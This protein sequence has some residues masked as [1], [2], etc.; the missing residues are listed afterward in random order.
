[1]FPTDLPVLVNPVQTDNLN[2]ATVFHDVQH[3]DV[4][5]LVEAITSTLGITNSL[6][7]TTIDYLVRHGV[8]LKETRFEG[9]VSP[10]SLSANQ[11]NYNPDPSS[12]YTVIRQNCSANVDITG[13][14]GGALG[15]VIIWINIGATNTQTFKNESGSS[16]AANRFSLGADVVLAAGQMAF[17]FYDS[18]ASR[19]KILSTGAS[20]GGGGAPTTAAYAI[21]AASPDG[22][23]VN[24]VAIGATPTGDLAGTSSV[25]GNVVIKGTHTDAAVKTHHLEAHDFFDTAI[26]SALVFATP[27]SVGATNV[28]GTADTISRGD[29]QHAGTAAFPGL[30]NIVATVSIA[31]SAADFL[32]VGF[33]IPTADMVAGIM[34][35]FNAQWIMTNTSGT[36]RSIDLKIKYGGTTIHTGNS[37]LNTGV[38]NKEAILNTFVTFRTI[39][40]SGTVIVGTQTSKDASNAEHT[41][42]TGTTTVNTTTN[43]A[44]ELYAAFPA[45]SALLTADFYQALLERVK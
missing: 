32:I 31:N 4:N 14:V 36:N 16:T 41:I 27:V 2:T 8:H 3:S 18:T 29:H 12:I 28:A 33:T 43:K 17:M 25:W 23:L 37:T 30:A 7:T 6:V 15:R 40:A 35:R 5:D 13:L 19:W 21:A 42:D 24:S 44:L 22:A 9:V 1:M 38:S 11:N 20:G 10:T 39:G 26:H 45:A 34:F